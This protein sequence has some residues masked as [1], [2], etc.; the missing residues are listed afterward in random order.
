M[1][2]SKGAKKPEMACI[3]A[4][5]RTVNEAKSFLIMCFSPRNVHQGIDLCLLGRAMAVKAALEP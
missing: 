4:A 3:F 5:E 2:D 1:A